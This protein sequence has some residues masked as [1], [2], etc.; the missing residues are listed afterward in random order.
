MVKGAPP[1]PHRNQV[2]DYGLPTLPPTSDE[3]SLLPLNIHHGKDPTPFPQGHEVDDYGIL[4]P[5][6]IE[7]S[8]PLPSVPH[9]KD[10]IPLLESE[11]DDY[12]I[13]NPPSTRRSL[14]PHD[15]PY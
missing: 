2:D 8:L 3:G 9:G 1:I 10:L 13:A 6:P 5:P 12:G 4:N 11:V 14:P 15:V 7:G